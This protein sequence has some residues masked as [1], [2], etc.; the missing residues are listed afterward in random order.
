MELDNN[1]LERTGKLSGTT[2]GWGDSGLEIK[3]ISQMGKEKITMGS[4]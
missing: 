2:W 3:Y 4:P 1:I